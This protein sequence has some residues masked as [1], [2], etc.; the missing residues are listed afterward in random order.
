MEPQNINY[1]YSSIITKMMFQFMKDSNI[2]TMSDFMYNY[3][4]ESI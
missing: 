1:A 4:K 3:N 2:I